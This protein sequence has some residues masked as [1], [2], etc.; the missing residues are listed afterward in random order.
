MFYFPLAELPPFFSSLFR[1]WRKPQQERPSDRRMVWP[2][3][4]ICLWG[5][6]QFNYQGRS[7]V[8]CMYHLYFS[9]CL[10]YWK[11][12]GS[13][14]KGVEYTLISIMCKSIETYAGRNTHPSPLSTSTPPLIPSPHHTQRK[15]DWKGKCQNIYSAS[16]PV[17]AF[18]VILFV[19]LYFS[20][21][22]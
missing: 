8:G 4:A 2:C 3:L 21:L 14:R 19:Y 12:L 10:V 22:T 17:V 18:V 9:N 7:R 1:A 11:K 13:N 20:V 6:R 15:K 16:L 5:T